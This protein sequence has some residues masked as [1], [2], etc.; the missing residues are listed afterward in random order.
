MLL[1]A[2]EGLDD[3]GCVVFD[4]IHYMAD[5]TRGTTWEE[6][7]ICM[8][9]HVQL[10]CLS[11]TV[12]NAREIADWI[13]DVHRET[14]LVYHEERAVPLEHLYL[15][16][17]QLCL[18]VDSEGRRV[19]RFAG[20]GGEYRREGRRPGNWGERR[21]RPKHVEAGPEDVV[22]ALKDEGLL[23]AIYFLFS[24][25]DVE[26]AAESCIRL[27]LANGVAR[28]RITQICRER[29][30]HLE[31]E[32]RELG[33]V[34]S[35]VRML[36]LGA[37]F[38]H[39][40]L[41][42]VLKV[43][44]EE[45]FSAGLLGVV[46]ATDTLSLGINMPARTVVVG[47]FSKFDGESRRILTPNEYRQLTGRAGRRGIDARGTAVVPYSP[48]VA[49][50]NVYEVVTGAIQ[51]VQSAFVVRYNTVLNLWDEREGHDPSERI[52]HLM[53]SSLREYQ[54]DSQLRDLRAGQAALR[55][56]AEVKDFGCDTC[57]PESLAEYDWLRRQLPRARKD[58]ER[59]ESAAALLLGEVDAR[60]WQPSRLAVRQAFRDF[61]GGEP[62]HTTAHGWGIYLSRPA[63]AQGAVALALFGR[64]ARLVRSY[65]RGG[66]PA[67]GRQ[68]GRPAR[69]AP[70]PLGRGRR[71]R[72]PA[73]RRGDHARRV[74]S[75]LARTPGR[76]RHRGQP[77]AWRRERRL[78][79][80]SALPPRESPRLGR[81]ARRSRTRSPRTRAVPARTGATTTRGSGRPSSRS[82]SSK[83]PGS[84]S[85]T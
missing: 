11:A 39:A 37:G 42:P 13:G 34:R 77:I 4:E 54:V 2:P 32:D 60:P 58:E 24:R 49:A 48:W 43:L 18:A 31:P 70:R 40:G 30:A 9:K 52:A 83:R 57:T 84:R 35:L 20:V 19:T 85:S 76:G 69:R 1:Q 44:V 53:A 67:R 7:I 21:P 36:P 5:P 64:S 80:G 66:L 8:P 26:E 41:L 17:G 23:P 25:R 6:A 50:E 65:S 79:R 82:G 71:R 3:V 62:L 45:L 78:R 56:R 14:D 46:V 22:R 16:D 81:H 10:V 28:A 12:A 68:T 72:P 61:R 74:G 47:E 63:E 15:L 33:Q 73:R 38:H 29:L 55:D 59:A 75:S 51:P 27:H